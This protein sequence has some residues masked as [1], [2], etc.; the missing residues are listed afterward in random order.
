MPVPVA[1]ERFVGRPRTPRS[2]RAAVLER[3]GATRSTEIPWGPSRPCPV[4]FSANCRVVGGRHPP[5]SRRRLRTSR[6]R[7]GC[8]P[9]GHFPRRCLAV[10]VRHPRTFESQRGGTP[11]LGVSCGFVETPSPRSTSGRALFDDGVGGWSNPT[12]VRSQ[13]AAARRA[14]P[15]PCRMNPCPRDAVADRSRTARVHRFLARLWGNVCHS[16]NSAR[17]GAAGRGAP[18][19]HRRR[20]SRPPGSSR[21][22]A[23][24]EQARPPCRPAP[25]FTDSTSAR[26][27]PAPLPGARWAPRPWR[28]AAR[29]PPV[30]Q[31]IQ[32]VEAFLQTLGD[33]D[34]VQPRRELLHG[35]NARTGDGA[36]P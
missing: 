24:V 14:G 32:G 15:N 18:R 25:G 30:G 4:L 35:A 16:R 10:G 27:S 3:N 9:R 5:Y 1:D 6:S 11:S 13:C 34:F 22:V 20:R 29:R 21:S 23:T 17:S 19:G 12:P 7:R 26:R 31:G 36:V 28:A 33:E 8:G 2:T